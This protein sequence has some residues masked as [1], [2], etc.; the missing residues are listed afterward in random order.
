MKSPSG[1]SPP[2]KMSGKTPYTSIEVQIADGAA[3]LLLNR[4]DLHNAF[5]EI[6]I[7]ELTQAFGELDRDPAVR[8]MVLGARGKSF[9]AGA[10]LN[11]MKKMSAYTFEQNFSDAQALANMLH[12]LYTMKK[13]T[14]AR[15]HGS[16]FAGGMG[17]VAACDIAIAAQ[18]VEF[19]L[20]EARL[21]LSPATISPYVIAAMG[22]RHARRYFLTAE[23][24]SA[25]EAFRIGFV[26][27]IVI[28]EELD[29]KIS[30]LL[31]H[32]LATGPN[33]VAACKDLVRSVAKAKIGPDLIKETATR[34]ANIR[35]TDEGREGI[36]SFL[37]KRKPA[38]TQSV[39]TESV[40][41][42][43]AKPAAK[44]AKK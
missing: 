22:E 20:S 4:P 3:L 23:R 14:I 12:A 28:G 8:A 44:K 31:R 16:A 26:H 13:P 42:D 29:A 33:A 25:A 43:K 18:D 39:Q 19:C 11:W 36:R 37:E 6:M 30:E 21:G 17:L 9:C 24:F 32:L 40:K 34:I 35:A 38:W 1:L 7:A 27:D 2:E 41:A 5:N 10:D 15:V